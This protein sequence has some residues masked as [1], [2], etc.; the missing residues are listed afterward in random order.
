MTPP[1]LPVLFAQA[2]AEPPPPRRSEPFLQKGEDWALVGLLTAALLVGAVVL[3]FVDRWRKRVM[4]ED[5]K[6][7]EELTSFRA[8]YERGEITEEEY[9]RL[10]QRVAERVKK[11]PMAAPANGPP[12]PGVP[13]TPAAA[14][15]PPPRPAPQGYFEDSDEPGPP[16]SPNG[17]PPTPPPA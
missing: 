2:E 16:P 10:R 7:G 1:T 17:A 4:I 15:S 12:V 3:Y 14:D 8:M 13:A 9:A 5:R 11:P 6:S